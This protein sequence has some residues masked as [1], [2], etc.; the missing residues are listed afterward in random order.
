METGS[1]SPD[2]EGWYVRTLEQ[3]ERDNRRKMALFLVKDAGIEF[4]FGRERISH[5]LDRLDLPKSGRPITRV[6]ASLRTPRA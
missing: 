6:F 3:L 2:I 5:V 1:G 4:S